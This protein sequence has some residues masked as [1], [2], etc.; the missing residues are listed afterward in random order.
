MAR[1]NLS[2]RIYYTEIGNIVPTV[3][4]S[5]IVQR[6][7]EKDRKKRQGGKIGKNACSRSRSQSLAWLRRR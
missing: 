6:E 7:E 1:G 4:H 2:A 5:A 3:N